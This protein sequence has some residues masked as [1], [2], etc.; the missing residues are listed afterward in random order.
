MRDNTLNMEKNKYTPV[1]FSQNNPAY[2]L[3]PEEQNGLV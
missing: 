2:F 1:D 3:N